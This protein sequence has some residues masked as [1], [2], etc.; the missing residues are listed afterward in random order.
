M[1]RRVAMIS[2]H[3][4]PLSCLGGVDSG[5]Q[6]VYVAHVAK[7]LAER[8]WEID[9]FT[10]RDSSTAPA[11]VPFGRGI[12]VIHIDAGPPNHVPK[13]ELLPFTGAF[14]DRMEAF[15]GNGRG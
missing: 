8:G 12:R 3:A 11:I 6:N 4:S 5:G 15:I 7:G 9:V 1:D 14:A 10:R 13:E 2:E